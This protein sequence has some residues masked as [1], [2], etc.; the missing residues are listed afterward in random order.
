MS[1][2][3]SG[4]FDKTH[5]QKKLKHF[6]PWQQAFKDSVYHKKNGKLYIS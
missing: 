2:L 6:L 3:I 1:P 4:L 5:G